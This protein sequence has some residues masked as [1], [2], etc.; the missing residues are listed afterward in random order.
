MTK[1]K[2]ARLAQLTKLKEQMPDLASVEAQLNEFCYKVKQSL[3]GCT[4]QSKR[5]TLTILDVQVVATPEKLNVKAIV[6][7]E[8]ITIERTSVC[9]LNYNEKLAY[10]NICSSLLSDY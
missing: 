8:F 6:P 4:F 2:I 5:L 1:R 9:M 7:L 3:D 10:E